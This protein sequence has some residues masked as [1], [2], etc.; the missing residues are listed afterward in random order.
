MGRETS[1]GLTLDMTTANL[2]EMAGQTEAL[3]LSV[4]PAISPIA[5]RNR[6]NRKRGKGTSAELA[7]Y[8]G[9]Q[10]VEGMNWEWDVQGPGGRLQSKRDATARSSAEM[11]RLILRI[12]SGDFLRGL[13]KVAP[14][15]RLASGTVYLLL[16]E[17]VGE[18][19]WLLPPSVLVNAA[20]V[21]LMIL[22]LPAFRDLVIAAK[23]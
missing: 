2:N 23:E 1:S 3:A 16:H 21:P 15:Q 18:R 6:N 7:K 9:W 10:N 13:F 8:L 19:G 4:A 11:A 12:P 14:R 22:P 17:W 20:G 5:R